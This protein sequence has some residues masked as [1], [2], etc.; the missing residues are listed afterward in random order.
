MDDLS[1]KIRVALVDQASAMINELSK[2]IEGVGKTAQQKVEWIKNFGLAVGTAATV[3]GGFAVN[4]FMDFEKTMSGVKAVLS[5]TTEEFE[6]LKNKVQ[7]VGKETV[8]SQ[9]E[10]ARATED[11]AKNGL[12]ASQILNGALDATANFASAAG[13]TLETSSGVVSD[14][15]NIFKLRAEDV[16]T[17]VDQM[18]GVTIA[19]KFGAEDYALALAQGGAAA[20][21]AGISFEDFNTTIAG[22]SSAFSSWSDAGTSFKVFTQRLIPQSDEAAAAMERLGLQFFDA[23]GK[24]KPMRDIAENLKTGLKWLTDEQRNNAL[25]TIFGTDAMRAAAMIAEQGA[26]WYDKLSTS[27]KNTDAAAQSATRLD[28]LAGSW[29]K[30]MGIVDVYATKLGEV[31][32]SFL[33][34][35]IDSLASWLENISTWFNGLSPTMQA[36]ILSI[37]SAVGII[38]A[39]TAA[40]GLIMTVVGPIIAW[41]SAMYSVIM[42]LVG[43]VS[44]SIWVIWSL[45]VAM[46]PIGWTIAAIVAAWVL[47]YEAWTNNWG[48]MRDTVLIFMDAWTMMMTDLGSWLFDIVER[49]KTAVADMIAGWT[50]FWESV[51]ATIFEWKEAIFTTISE[52]WTAI[53]DLFSASWNA[54]ALFMTTALN[55]YVNFWKTIWNTV[56]TLLKATWDGIKNIIST[57]WTGTITF[58][59]WGWESLKNLF[60]SGITALTGSWTA[61]GGGLK[62]TMIGVWEGIKSTIA[63]GI[64]WVIEKINWVLEKINAATSKV[65]GPQIPLIPKLAFADGGIVPWSL[66]SPTDSVVARVS[67]WELILNKAQQENVANQLQNGGGGGTVLQITITGN[68]FMGSDP[69]MMTS[70]GDQLLTIIQPHLNT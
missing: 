24:I 22:I 39:F 38:V 10:I 50:G 7:E 44:A 4:K 17:A 2:N 58:L 43:W 29:E 67:P 25:T 26:E 28:N 45:I 31:I 20:R 30:L 62:S 11:L 14:A 35:A 69:E 55:A 51:G 13:T 34:P 54:I 23:Q 68:S 12:N 52:W 47:L 42:L 56:S 6:A 18:T 32:N 48:G 66:S 70:I 49:T 1:L 65:G 37:G 36:V 60:A 19:S 33:R 63:S 40:L 27:I 57:A 8:F 64:N 9:G 15:L 5:P 61:F 59:T 16:S 3:V 21:V 53:K 41:V 46:W